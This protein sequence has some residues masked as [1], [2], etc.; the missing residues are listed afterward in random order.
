MNKEDMNYALLFKEG[1]MT[2]EWYAKRDFFVS[3]R[4]DSVHISL[5]FGALTSA[6][7]HECAFYKNL[8]LFLL[9]IICI[10]IASLVWK[11]IF[12]LHTAYRSRDF[13]HL[14]RQLSCLSP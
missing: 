3:S 12:Y 4:K 5:S 9:Q 8:F 6:A 7:T 10:C 14:R 13:E 1:F 2:G 11:Y